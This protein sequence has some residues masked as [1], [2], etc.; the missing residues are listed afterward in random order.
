MAF[1]V[2]AL[3]ADAPAAQRTIIDA[4]PHALPAIRQALAAL[5]RAPL[6]V[7]V[8]DEKYVASELRSRFRRAEAFVA[9]GRP[10]VY[11]TSH[12]PVLRAAVEG[13]PAH[14]CALAA[15][16]WHEMAH[17]DGADEAEARRREEVLW[18]RFLL[19]GRVERA[20]GLRYLKTLN[21]RSKL[22]LT[23]PPSR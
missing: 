14:V 6:R 18:T 5:P 23:S 2:L 13:S 10:V 22:A 17:L 1:A 7:S 16:I 19:D 9:T 4:A 12:S 11:L 8:V 21:D 15:V 3:P 20:A